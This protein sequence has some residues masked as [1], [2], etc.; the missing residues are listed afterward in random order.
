MRLPKLL[1]AFSLRTLALVT[2]CLSI[3]LLSH[4]DTTGAQSQEHNSTIP[5]VGLLTQL[6]G[7][8][9]SVDE[10]EDTLAICGV[11]V[12]I[13]ESTR[14]D[15]RVALL[16]DGGAWARV[17]AEL[18]DDGNLAAVRIKTI[19]PQ[20][21]LRVRGILE[22]EEQTVDGTILTVDGITVIDDGSAHRAGHIAVGERVDIKADCTDDGLTATQ[23]VGKAS[24]PGH[25]K[26][27]LTHFVGLIENELAPGLIGDWI[28]DGQ[29]VVVDSS[30][31]I[32]QSKGEAKQGA[33]VKVVAEVRSDGS[34][35]AVEILVLPGKGPKTSE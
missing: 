11:E 18:G 5:A 8:V 30:D 29:T 6:R 15:E 3:I 33:K 20:P 28:V 1:P 7:P 23:I 31:V 35:V 13:T 10:A 21:F 24:P 12:Q 34:L 16:T 17:Y 14:I 22:N 25:D 32:D 19:E 26:P 9:T 27:V 4:Y 2:A